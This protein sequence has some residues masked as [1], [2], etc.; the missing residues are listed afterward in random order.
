M[1]L[2]ATLSTKEPLRYSPAGVPILN[3]RLTHGSE[4]MEAGAPRTVRCEI[5]AVAVG[6]VAI[7]LARHA[8]GREARFDGFLATR[9]RYEIAELHVT[10]F[11]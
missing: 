8:L 6:E 2:T 11:S 7:R 1:T 4:Q 10:E 5:P 9:R 3:C